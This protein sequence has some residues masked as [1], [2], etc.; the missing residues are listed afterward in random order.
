MQRRGFSIVSSIA[1][2]S[3]VALGIAAF[4]GNVN[5]AEQNVDSGTPFQPAAAM[6]ETRA[7]DGP[8]SEFPNVGEISAQT[9]IEIPAPT[10]STF[11][12]A[13]NGSLGVNGYL[14]DVS[15]SDSFTSYVDGYHDVDVGNVTGRAV[16]GLSR[17]NTY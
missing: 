4:A 13:W 1:Y 10:R 8:A 15:T 17:G 14:L 3:G 11:M 6:H 12:A 7:G 2:A 16:A 9:E 5:L